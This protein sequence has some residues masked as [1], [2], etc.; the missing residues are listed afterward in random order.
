MTKNNESNFNLRV[1][2]VKSSVDV[3]NIIDDFELKESQSASFAWMVI[4]GAKSGLLQMRKN[5]KNKVYSIKIT[6]DKNNE[7]FRMME[8]ADDLVNGEPVFLKLQKN[9]KV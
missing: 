4:D 5:P 8:V 9:P 2:D 3:T 7:I 1:I 6:D